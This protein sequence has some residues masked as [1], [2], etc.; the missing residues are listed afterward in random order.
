MRWFL[1]FW[2]SFLATAQ[3]S[4]FPYTL[5]ITPISNTNLPGLHSYAFGMWQNKWVFIGGRLDG[6]HAR[7]PF[8]AFAAN[9]NNTMLIVYQPSTNQIWTRSVNEL[10]VGLKEQ[11]QSTNMNFYQD[12]NHLII[13]G[14][15][16]FAASVNDHITHNKLTT[17]D[18]SVLVPAIQNNSAIAS[19][20][21]QITNENFAITGGQLGKID[22]TYYLVGGHRFDGRYN[23]MGN[24]TFTQTYSNQIRKFQLDLSSPTLAI[25]NYE[26]ITDPVHLRRR[27]YNLVP[28]VFANNQLG[29]LISS[30]VFQANA[31]LPFL[32]PV[33]IKAMGHEAIT[34]FNQ[35]LSNYHS[36]KVGLWDANQQ[37]MHS[38]FFGGISQYYYQNNTLIQDDQV[39]FVKT[40]SRVTRSQNGTYQ[41]FKFAQEM[42]ALKG[43]GAE[44]IPNLNLPHFSNEV[45]KLNEITAE[46]FVIGHLY[47]GILSTTI[48]PF[49]N[50]ATSTQ[51][52]ADASLYEVKLVKD[53]TLG[54]QA[55]DGKNPFAVKVL[56]NPIQQSSFRLGFTLPYVANLSYFITSFD[57]KLLAE[58]EIEDHTQGY[59]EMN[60][61][62]NPSIQ[63]DFIL[64]MVLDHKYYVSQ[65]VLWRK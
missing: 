31:D 13:V 64:T 59:Q 8:N 25:S 2:M 28:Q 62:L 50:N 51:T 1:F 35:Y 14:G 61:A 34:S 20:F 9:S 11:L 36:G 29:Y 17:I 58:G 6:I 39:P 12:G 3:T 4:D 56:Q 5:Q 16:S 52:Q 26:A 38:L 55:L 37:K 42:P 40:I 54:A 44:F 49:S 32:Y 24:P 30:G 53:T 41:E 21:K 48:N 7:Q 46:E 57:G 63:T 22:N 60:F 33:E 65:K 10:A 15:Y 19:A 23:P 45:L 47:G 27:D 43:A 18:L